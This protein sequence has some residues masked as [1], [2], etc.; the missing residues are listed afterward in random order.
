MNKLLKWIIIGLI[1]LVITILFVFSVSYLYT[2]SLPSVNKSTY[3][4]ETKLVLPHEIKKYQVLNKTLKDLTN[5]SQPLGLYFDIDDKVYE[6]IDQGF[7]NIHLEIFTTS[8][9]EN[10]V[11]ISINNYMIDMSD[12][13]IKTDISKFIRKDTNNILITPESNIDEFV[14]SIIVS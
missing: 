12:H 1:V 6:N 10:I 13:Y 2:L 14:I 4:D 7:D 3:L 5:N 8:E 11:T 9:N